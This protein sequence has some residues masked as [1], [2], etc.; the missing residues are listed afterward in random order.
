LISVSCPVVAVTVL[1]VEYGVYPQVEILDVYGIE[2]GSGLIKSIENGMFYL[3][4]ILV[5]GGPFTIIHEEHPDIVTVY[6]R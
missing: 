3:E 6:L 1:Q 4:R 5:V 2:V